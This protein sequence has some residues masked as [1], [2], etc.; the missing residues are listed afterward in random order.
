MTTI[1]LAAA[2]ALWPDTAIVLD[3]VT[4]IPSGEP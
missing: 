1:I 3:D 4:V 2:I